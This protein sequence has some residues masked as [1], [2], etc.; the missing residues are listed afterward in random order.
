MTDKK[1]NKQF[2]ISFKLN[3]YEKIDD[4]PS[5]LADLVKLSIEGTKISYAPYSNFLVGAAVLTE[6]GK[7]FIGANQEN[8]AYPQCMCGERVAIYHAAMASPNDAIEAVAISVKNKDKDIFEPVMPC[9]ACR[10]VISEY[11]NRYNK[12]IMILLRTSDDKVYV[13]NSVK[14]ILPLGFNQSFL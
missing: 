5:Q 9:G 6:S 4:L 12:D 11:E 7:M 14:D 13:V 2:E 8:A 3:I 1:E 10:Q